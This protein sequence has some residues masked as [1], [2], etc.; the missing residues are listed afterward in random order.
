MLHLYVLVLKETEGKCCQ[1]PSILPLPTGTDI[2]G[3]FYVSFV[4]K[5]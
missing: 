3:G 2:V 5:Y 4:F 1:I